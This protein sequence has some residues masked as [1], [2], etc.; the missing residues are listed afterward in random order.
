MENMYTGYYIFSDDNKTNFGGVAANITNE[1]TMV[2]LTLKDKEK[3]F[4]NYEL[5]LDELNA[6]KEQ[7]ERLSKRIENINFL[8]ANLPQS[9]FDENK[10]LSFHN[11]E[12]SKCFL[13]ELLACIQDMSWPIAKNAVPIL[14]ENQKYLNESI[15]KAFESEDNAWIYN[16]LYFLMRE[17]EKESIHCYQTELERLKKTS[18][19]S[20]DNEGIQEI[21]D[22]LLK[23]FFHESV[24]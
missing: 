7:I 14:L 24:E 2:K 4:I 6:V 5:S 20:K 1:Q 8:K 12:E 22:T 10:L 23:K 18:S 17:F 3:N 9:K 15:V 19:T 21:A 11:I 16:I 13:D